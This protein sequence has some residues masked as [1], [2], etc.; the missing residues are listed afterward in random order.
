MAAAMMSSV[1]V[2]A[3]KVVARRGRAQVAVRASSG[4][5]Y[6]KSLPGAPALPA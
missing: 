4:Q 3:P 5:D 1:S 2:F 6:M